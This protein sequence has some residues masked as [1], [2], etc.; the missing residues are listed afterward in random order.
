[1]ANELEQAL[2]ETGEQPVYVISFLAGSL[3]AETKAAAEAQLGKV[4]WVKIKSGSRPPQI[5]SF[6]KESK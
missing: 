2:S 1:M 5:E 6:R 3:T 4:V